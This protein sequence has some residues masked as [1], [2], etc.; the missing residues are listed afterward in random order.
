MDLSSVKR[1][2]PT[3]AAEYQRTFLK[4][5]EV[6]ITVRGTLGG[7]VVVPD[8]LSGWNISREVALIAP[9]E[10]IDPYYLQYLLA[11]PQLEAWFKA[12]LRGV[13]YTGINLE[14]LR[15]A[16][17]IWCCI[18][19]QREIVKLINAKMSI[20]DAAA[21]EVEQ[22]LAKLS[23]L[24]NAILKKA[25]CGQLVAQDARDEAASVLL[26]R[27]QAEKDTNNK[28]TKRRRAA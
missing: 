4:G 13:A 24:S 8:A 6:L 23:V 10:A 14:T 25:F 26:N 16:P 17:I 5:G 12:R 19:E 22:Q 28:N 18:D 11:S 20:V 27:I 3:I 2:S 21:S 15:E 1:I 7:V 9:S